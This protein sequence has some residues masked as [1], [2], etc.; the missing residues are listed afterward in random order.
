MP[1]RATPGPVRDAITQQVQAVDAT[2]QALAAAPTTLHTPPGAATQ[3]T[4]VPEPA[5]PVPRPDSAPAPA[6]A[7]GYAR[8]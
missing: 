8:R 2:S 5:R 4:L 1:D 6:R 3:D 7:V